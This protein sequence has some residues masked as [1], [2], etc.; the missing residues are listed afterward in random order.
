MTSKVT[1]LKSSTA[2]GDS[3]KRAIVVTPPNTIVAAVGVIATSPYIQNRFSSAN[4]QKIEEQQR[5]GSSQKKKRRAKPPKD[6]KAVYEGSRHVSNEGWDGIP[7]SAFRDAMINATRSLEVDMIRTKM[8]IRI[9][10]DGYD[11]EDHTPLVRITKGKPRMDIRPVRIGMNQSDLAARAMFD[12]WEASIRIEWD[13]DIF[14]ASDIVNLL[15]RAGKYVG[16]GAGRQL[17]KNSAGMGMGF[18]EVKV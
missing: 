4:R 17:S 2:P 11:K 3:P 10:A 18:F 5:E 1:A 15:A 6:F 7:C 13:G 14:Q 9:L 12:Q 8:F 16:I